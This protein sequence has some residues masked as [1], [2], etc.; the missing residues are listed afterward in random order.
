M[1]TIELNEQQIEYL[2]WLLNLKFKEYDAFVSATDKA[3]IR[4]ILAKLND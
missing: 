2:K 1:K 4:G 3:I